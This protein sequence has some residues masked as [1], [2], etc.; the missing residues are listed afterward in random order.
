MRCHLSGID[1]A[2][3]VSNERHQTEE[4]RN[5]VISLHETQKRGEARVYA[6]EAALIERIRSGDRDAFR[7]V[8]YTHLTLPTNREV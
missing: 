6:G 5:R 8:S 2:Y 4:R 7:A 3:P 1:R